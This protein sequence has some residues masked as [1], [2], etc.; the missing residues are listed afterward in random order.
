MK[1]KVSLNYKIEKIV[2]AED[3]YLAQEEFCEQ[4]QNECEKNNEELINM[5]VGNYKSQES[6]MIKKRFIVEIEV[7]EDKI[8]DKYPNY[9]INFGTKSSIVSAKKFIKHLID[10]FKY[11]ANT[12]MPKD[13]LKKWGYAKR[14]IKEIK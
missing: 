3:E 10:D 14:V 2:E 5:R 7:D 11:E 8:W 12:N 9:S 6:K 1:Y 4:L 13:G